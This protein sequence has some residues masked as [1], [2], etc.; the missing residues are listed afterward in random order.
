M[1]LVNCHECS[2][3]MS[4]EAPTCPHCGAPSIYIDQTNPKP[5]KKKTSLGEFLGVIFLG[6]III[7]AVSATLNSCIKSSPSNDQANTENALRLSQDTASASNENSNQ[8]VSPNSTQ[9]N[10]S[11]P[12]APPISV[13][14]V[15][16]YKDYHKNEIAADSKYKDKPLIITGTILSINKGIADSMYLSLSAGDS[17]SLD[18]VQANLNES[19]QSRA[20]SLSKGDVVRVQC[21]GGMMVIGYPHGEKC[22]IIDTKHAKD[23]PSDEGSDG[24]TTSN[25]GSAETGTLDSNNPTS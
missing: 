12:P 10:N 24:Q 5:Y 23:T 13:T 16:F 17:L 25:Q 2:G 15:K 11:T 14:A 6:I 7:F 22:T 3:K 9:T 18:S 1:A 19:E 20:A 21:V 4:S 8:T